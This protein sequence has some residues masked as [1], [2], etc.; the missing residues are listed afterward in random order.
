MN[1]MDIISKLY[2]YFNPKCIPDILL[3]T[4]DKGVEKFLNIQEL[5]NV[6][7]VNKFIANNHA[8]NKEIKRKSI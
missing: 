1:I 2:N 4:I 7:L 6:A 5:F 3:Y 8:V